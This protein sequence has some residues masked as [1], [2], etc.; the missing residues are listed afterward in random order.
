[1]Y[2]VLIDR[3]CNGDRSNDDF[4]KDEYGAGDD[5]RFQGGDLKGIL[6][7]LPYIKELGFDSLWITPPVHNQWINPGTSCRGYHGYWTYDFTRVDPHFGTLA[8]YKRLVREAHRLGIRVIQDIVVNHTGNYFTVDAQKYDPKDPRKGW[9]MLDGSY[10]P[11]GKVKAP[12]DPVFGMN[13]PNDPAHRRAGVYNF[14]PN[15]TEFADRQQTLN[16][17]LGDLDDINLRSPLAANRMKEIYRYWIEA[18]GIDGL[19]VDTV[20]YTPE[21]FYED[22]LYSRDPKNLGVKRFARMRGKKDFFV[23]GEAW[24]YD[25]PGI[26]RYLRKG[27]VKRLDSAIDLP[28]NEVLTQVFYRKLPTR[29]IRACLEAERVDPNLWVNFLDNHDIERMFSRADWDAVKQSLVSLFTLPGIPCV[30]YG[31]ENGFKEPRPNMFSERCY[32]GKSREHRFLK[33]LIALRKAHPVFSRGRAKVVQDAEASGILAYTVEHGEETALAVFNTSRN[34]MYFHFPDHLEV[35]QVL[36]SSVSRP[37]GRWMLLDPLGYRLFL[38]SKTPG[39]ASRKAAAV[40]LR[41]VPKGVLR[42]DVRLR[43]EV[44][45]NEEL[46]DLHLLADADYDSRVPVPSRAKGSL[47]F[48]STRL[49]NGPHRLSLLGRT[50]GGGFVSSEEAVVRVRNPYRTLASASV[51]AGSQ[52]GIHGNLLPPG[53][54]S[55]DG[56]LEMRRVRVAAC[57]KDL[58]IQVRMRSVTDEW[59]PPTGFDHAYVN[60]FL[61]LPGRPGSSVIPK[62]KWAPK[63]FRFHYGFLFYG[64]GVIA[65]S[66]R[67]CGRDAFGEPLQEK[68]GQDVDKKRRT[69]TFRFPSELFEGVRD[70]GGMK[71]LLT[72]WDGYLGKFQEVRGKPDDW[73]FSVR[74]PMKPA[75]VPRVFSHAL[76]RIPRKSK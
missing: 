29:G 52:N 15:I 20:F 21:E 58:E 53:D 34:R 35:S 24:S 22:F 27:K 8:D 40:S 12:R 46:R 62:L 6:K 28:L 37:E 67:D 76:L 17:T 45:G 75:A 26:N 31:T 11:A 30:Y 14:T 2:F 1:M 7:R 50:Q 72:T 9:R 65:Y 70:F 74:G 3:F 10:P 63:G 60:V 4:G 55:Y 73:A 54:A 64:W 43:F 23:F 42:G 47:V 25:I 48:D 13:D 71:V 38:V 5:D 33:R 51:P 49:H 68:I 61:D 66:H 69:L 57:G 36:L 41:K 32:Q 18:V 16:W 39:P 44:S 19:R 59:N 56:Q